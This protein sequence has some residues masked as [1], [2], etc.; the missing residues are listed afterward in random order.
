MTQQMWNSRR[1]TVW[2]GFGERWTFT[3]RAW[4]T[5]EDRAKGLPEDAASRAVERIFYRARD[6]DRRVLLELADVPFFAARQYRRA[7]LLSLVKMRVGRMGPLLLFSDDQDFSAS[8]ARQGSVTTSPERRVVAGVMAGRD[9]IVFEGRQYRLVLAPAASIRG[10]RDDFVG[11]SANEARSVLLRLG[12]GGALITQAQRDAIEQAAEMLVDP[13]SGNGAGRLVLLRRVVRASITASAE[14]ATTPS[15]LRPAKKDIT[16]KFVEIGTGRPIVGAALKLAGP[17]GQ[18]SRVTTS[19]AGTVK[20]SDS[21]PGQCVATSIIKNA[22]ADASFVPGAPG[23]PAALGNG[24][25]SPLDPSYLVEVDDYRVKTGDTAVSIAQ[26]AGVTWDEIAR[27]NWNTT[28]PS[29]LQDCFRDCLGCTKKTADGKSYVFD[30]TDDPGTILIPRA[31]T[32]AFAVGMAHTILVAPLRSVYLSLENDSGLRIPGAGYEAV[33]S[34]GTLRDGRL[35]RSGIARLAG[36]PEGP[37]SVT[38]PDR[39]DLLAR[40]L[41]ASVRRAFDD[42]TTGPLL[43]L[44]GQEQSIIEKAVDIYEQCFNDLTGQGLAADIDQV[45]TDSDARPPLIFLCSL[46]GIPIEGTDGATV[47]PGIGGAAD[48][49]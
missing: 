44:L 24:G 27:F 16:L 15:A 28:D 10:R 29:K 47:Q 31:W 3:L 9:T 22:T 40:S 18:E 48:D 34:D 13:V 21:V 42:E 26:D 17:D 39:E 7:D 46:A 8:A 5:A 30:D 20:L 2:D 49:R 12:R 35:G 19:S 37:F 25:G 43:F 6:E 38:Y 45:V 33:F 32:G 41:A 1:W 36:V 23:P 14:P 4:A 11:V